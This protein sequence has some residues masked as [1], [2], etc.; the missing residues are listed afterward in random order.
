MGDCLWE[1][2]KNMHGSTKRLNSAVTCQT[3]SVRRRQDQK[4]WKDKSGGEVRGL[5][6]GGTE[7]AKARQKKLKTLKRSEMVH[8][9]EEVAGGEGGPAWLS[10]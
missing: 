10:G 5:S 2:K 7:D 4:F 1:L 9:A 8:E 3:R 6:A